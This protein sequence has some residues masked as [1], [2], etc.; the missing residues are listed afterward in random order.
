MKKCLIIALT[1]LF[2]VSSMLIPIYAA[3]DLETVAEQNF[4][5]LPDNTDAALA[6]LRKDWQVTSDG[7]CAFGVKGFGVEDGALYM[8]S[9]SGFR[10]DKPL[11]GAY[12]FSFDYKNPGASGTASGHMI[13]LRNA[14]SDPKNLLFETVGKSG[15]TPLG[16]SGIGM[17][18]WGHYAG[19]TAVTYEDEDCVF[20]YTTL[21]MDIDIG[22][23]FDVHNEF[24]H[25]TVADDG[26]GTIRLSFNGEEKIVIT[27]SGRTKVIPAT[28]VM[29]VWTSATVEA[30][31]KTVTKEGLL[32]AAAN[33]SVGFG[34]RP[35]NDEVGTQYIDNLVIRT[36]APETEPPTEEP[37]EPATEALTEAPT[38]AP[39]EAPTA[40]P[41]EAPTEAPTET[42]TT[43]VTEAD[44]DTAAP[45][46][47]GAEQASDTEPASN[48]G[49]ASVVGI[50]P[51]SMLT[52]AAAVALKHRHI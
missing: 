42:P 21:M 27:L 12:E 10:Y 9:F 46:D 17:Y 47:T 34:K 45:V 14:L 2:L 23:G 48:S 26:A 24:V 11:N 32:I 44:A 39:T 29:D 4:D 40:T 38:D 50:L 35:Y 28:T 30:G 20:G 25:V 37:T 6:K 41:T 33:A 36:A 3:P 31:G 13:F 8:S 7:G 1:L 5:N 52:A 18:I 51:L 16:K 43:P 22:S 49:C 15:T 19:L